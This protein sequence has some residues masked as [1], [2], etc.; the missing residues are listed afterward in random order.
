[1]DN[2]L[3]VLVVDDT[4]TYRKVVGDL[5]SKLPDIEVVGT[6][7]NG[8]IA[9]QKMEQLHPDLLML[10]VEM[11]EMDGLAVLRSLRASNSQTGAIVLSAFSTEGAQT[12]L[13]ALGLGAFDFL[14]KPSD[15]SMDQNIERLTREL[16]PK[17][18]AFARSRQVSRIL[19]SAETG[20][21]A[22]VPAHRP[23][24]AA[25]KPAAPPAAP[26]IA[27]GPI[28]VVAIGISTGGPKALTDMLPCLPANLP[29]PVL[30]VQHMP[31]VFT[32]SLADDLD[33]RCKLRVAEACDGQPVAKGTILIAPGGKQM[34]VEPGS[35]ATVRITDDA[36]ENNCKPSVDYLFRSVV[37]VYGGR[38]LGVIMTGMG[39]DGTAGC[40]RMKRCG[41]T[42]IAQDQASCVVFGMPRTPVEEGLADVVAPLD[43]I[44]A[45]IVRVIGQGGRY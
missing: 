29:V 43:R 1:M 22:P 15:G 36:P 28:Q 38:S 34:R 24:E 41:G 23:P 44:A 19:R 14:V 26:A 30:I 9:M 18:A 37:D 25:V 10:D 40:R 42:L 45:E 12:T 7:A 4:V 31:P 5:L 27:V 32:K 20:P 13:N 35:P 6:A 17:L 3:R 16:R 8:K 33:T 11:P 39:N 21:K 2:T